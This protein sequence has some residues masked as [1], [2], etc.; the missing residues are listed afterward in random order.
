MFYIYQL[1]VP[2]AGVITDQMKHP[3]SKTDIPVHFPHLHI[4]G[5]GFPKIKNIPI[6]APKS[7][8][9]GHSLLLNSLFPMRGS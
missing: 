1:N 8:H 6:I 3:Y 2:K 5:N 9:S 7:I 4:F